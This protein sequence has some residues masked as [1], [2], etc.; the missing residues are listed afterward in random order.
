MKGRSLTALTAFLLASAAL[1]PVPASAVTL[2][3]CTQLATNLAYGLAGNAVIW[4]S[5]TQGAD[6]EG[7]M[8]PSA[9]IV[10]ATA[11]VPAYCKVNLQYSAKSGP[12]Y[13]YATGQ[14]QTIGIVIGLPLN[15]T[16]GGVPTNPGGFSWTAV[17]GAWNGKVENLG[18]GGYRGSLSSVTAPVTGGYIGANSDGGHNSGTNGN[19]NAYTHNSGPNG[20]SISFGSGLGNFAVIESTHQIDTGEYTDYEMESDHQMYMWA[21][22]LA[23]SYYGQ[24]PIRN[25]WS[26]CSQG[27]REGLEQAMDF[28]YAY[29]GIYAGAIGGFQQEFW[30]SQAWPQLVNRDW[31]VGAGDSAITVGQYD[32]VVAAA[33]AACDVEGYDTVRDGVVD[34]PRQCTYDPLK[35][36]TV[37]APSAGGT[38]TAGANCVDTLQ[39]AAI[40]KIWAGPRNHLNQPY[41]Y[42]WQKIDQADSAD[43][44]IGPA[45][46]ES[47]DEIQASSIIDHKDLY[48]SATNEYSSR[49][50]AATNPL[51]EQQPIALEDEF[52]LGIMGAPGQPVAQPVL[53]ENTNN[54]SNLI[55]NFYSHCKNGPGNCKFV[56][57]HGGMDTNIQWQQSLYQIRSMATAWGNGTADFTGLGTWLRSYHAPGVAHCG[58]GV[59][60]SPV[61][62]TLPDGQTQVFDD[63]VSWVETG[64]PPHSAGDATR[65]GILATGPGTFG[66]RPICPWPTTA[67]YNGTGST[68][69]ASNYTCGGNLDAYPP[70]AGTNNVAAVCQDLVTAFGNETSLPLN[71]AELGIS[72]AQCPAP[73][74]VSTHDFN[75]D[76]T[77]DMLWRDTSGN[78]GMWLMNG[79]SVLSTA[80]LG[81]VP[82]TWSVVG[83]RDFNGDGTSDILW[84]DTSGNVGIWFM[85]GTTISSTTVL[86]NVPT[87]WSVAGTGDF[88]NNANNDILWRDNLGNLTIWF[89]NGTSISQV[90]NLGNVPV[91]WTVA[92]VDSRGDIFWRNTTTGDVAIWTMN[93]AT[94]TQSVDLGTVPLSWSIAGIGDFDANGSTDI[95]WRDTSGNVGLWLMNG[96]SILSSTVLGNVPLNWTVAQVGDVNGDGKSDILWTDNVGD[97]GVWFMSG[98]TILSSKVYG[99]V[100]TAWSVQALN[101]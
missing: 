58:N 44:Q 93:G 77:S 80:V 27:G 4:Q 5:G 30:N 75:G 3:T 62:V 28:G 83:Q 65:A 98:A 35:D 53:N 89:M 74:Q 56:T 43:M 16:D 9:T 57:W 48:F 36:P 82:T 47:T 19:G 99:N 96:T 94:V 20:S 76:G 81:N 11:T 73:D 34:D 46:F 101:D 12:A 67:I 78:V 72:P 42:G 61:A 66:T 7:L 41:W 88:N 23:N 63:M 8:T 100:G 17:N 13:G 14:T 87:T 71:Y 37:I 91:N 97:V 25:Y 52:V 64:V 85:N 26:G 24:T 15:S 31:V 59:G 49:F 60:A 79:A 45:T 90:A 39:A 40:D 84:R 70:T 50:L 86:G 38:C 95:L 10:P 54:W 2:P 1:T 32:N 29:D 92:G 69:V 6:N 51:S 68:A 21:A 22:A 55:T 18:G 33:T